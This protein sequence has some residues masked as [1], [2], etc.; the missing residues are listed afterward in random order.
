[1]KKF[2]YKISSSFN[3]STVIFCF[4]KLFSKFFKLMSKNISLFKFIEPFKTG[5]HVTIGTVFSSESITETKIHIY[6]FLNIEVK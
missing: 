4:Q 3:I 1:V 6:I 2:Q 5:V